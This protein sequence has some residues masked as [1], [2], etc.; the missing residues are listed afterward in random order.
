MMQ[1]WADILERTQRGGKLLP[2][3]GTAA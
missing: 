3:R 2:F 1:E